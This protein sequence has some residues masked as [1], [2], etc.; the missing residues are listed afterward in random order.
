[1]YTILF[2][3]FLEKTKACGMLNDMHTRESG[4]ERTQGKCERVSKN[5]RERVKE[6][7][8]SGGGGTL[9]VR[10]NEQETA[11]E[12]ERKKERE[13]E[14]ERERARET[15]RE[16]ERERDRE[17]ETDAEIDTDKQT[18]RPLQTG[19]GALWGCP[20]LQPT[21]ANCLTVLF[22]Y[23]YMQFVTRIYEYSS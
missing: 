16:R 18:D 8:A 4:C 10:E 14:R 9:G 23:M 15:E 20:K 21:R 17:R 5:Q 1:V 2:P 12:R 6:R 3:F 7:E 13:R 11:R 19:A 22:M